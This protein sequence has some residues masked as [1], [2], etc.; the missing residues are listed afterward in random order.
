[1]K[2]SD[3]QGN[4]RLTDQKLSAL[5]K[6]VA[7]LTPALSHPM[8]EGDHS[9]RFLQARVRNSLDDIIVSLSHRMGEGQ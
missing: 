5:K 1:M 6:G 2:I 4:E 8:G 3:I 7:A 9:T